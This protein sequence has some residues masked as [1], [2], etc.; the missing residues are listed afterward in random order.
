MVFLPYCMICEHLFDKKDG[1][2]NTDPLY[3]KAFPDGVG[4]PEEIILGD[5]REECANGIGYVDRYR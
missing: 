1:E 4:I 2:K 3:C 5:K